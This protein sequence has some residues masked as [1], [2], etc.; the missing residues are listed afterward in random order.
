MPQACAQDPIRRAGLAGQEAKASPDLQRLRFLRTKERPGPST[1]S[2][3]SLER[4]LG[5]A[6]VQAVPGWMSSPDSLAANAIYKFRWMWNLRRSSAGPVFV[7]YMAYL[8]KKTFPFSYWTEIIP[9]T[10]DCWPRYYD[11]WASFY[12]RERT[13]IAFI[14]ARQSAEYFSL[15]LPRMKTVWLP[16]ACD[17]GEYCPS[18]EW[19]ERSIDVLEMGRRLESYHE[20]IVEGLAGTN[21]VHLYERNGSKSIF[22]GRDDL[23]DG[24]ARTKIL[25]CFPRSLTHP[26]VAEGVETVTYRYF[27]SMAS[28]CLIVGHAPQ[29]LIDLFGYNPVVEV[30]NGR[31]FEQIEWLLCNLDSF[32]GLVE[33]NYTRLL[34]VGTWKSRVE[35]ILEVLS[36]HPAFK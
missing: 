5:E 21:R 31:E 27:Q 9:Y 32:S 7:N 13:R 1:Y 35:T 8:E 11:W 22:S 23:I 12:R 36:E 17:P 15:K 34:E 25:I 14:T 30:Q 4:A 19:A 24:L 29:E 16:E 18:R 26:E 33:R 6:G 20:R 3:F 28:K 2:V 10:F